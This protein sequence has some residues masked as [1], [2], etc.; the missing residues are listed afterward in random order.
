M[1]LFVLYTFSV[2][3]ISTNL[4]SILILNGSYFKNRK[5]NIFFVLACKDLDLALQIKRPTTPTDSSSS[6]DR[7]NYKKWEHSSHMT[8]MIIKR[9]IPKAFRS[10]LFE[11]I[12]NAK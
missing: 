5:E 3:N 1:N 6:V 2:A 12:T 9:G 7:V 8:L 10:A 11:K 4:N